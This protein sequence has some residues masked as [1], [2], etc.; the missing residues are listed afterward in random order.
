MC[1]QILKNS[2]KNLTIALF[3]KLMDLKKILNFFRKKTFYKGTIQLINYILNLKKNS[4][5]LLI[6]FFFTIKKS[7][8][9]D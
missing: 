9:I 5:R 3:M 4:N 8:L 7:L 1:D 2:F 6:L